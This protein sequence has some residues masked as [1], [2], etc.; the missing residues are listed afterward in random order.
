MPV[1]KTYRSLCLD[2]HFAKFSHATDT[3]ALMAS[4]PYEY[5]FGLNSPVKPKVE[6]KPHLPYARIFRQV[7]YCIPHVYKGQLKE[8]IKAYEYVAESSVNYQIID[9]KYHHAYHGLQDARAFH[10][11]MALKQAEVERTLAILEEEEGMELAARR[12]RTE[13]EAIKLQIQKNAEEVP[14]LLSRTQELASRREAICSAF[15]ALKKQIY[16]EKLPELYAV[17]RQ[18]ARMKG[19]L[20]PGMEQ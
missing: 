18:V 20:P 1:V 12:K 16:D 14:D 13:L 7:D 2:A 15:T 5:Y 4:N 8:F 19:E 11:I 9:Q 17:V 3:A 10:T 6:P